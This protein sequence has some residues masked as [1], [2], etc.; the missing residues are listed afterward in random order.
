MGPLMYTSRDGLGR[1]RVKPC[2]DLR[3]VLSALRDG[4]SK[5]GQKT[6]PKKMG[7]ATIRCISL[8]FVLEQ[9]GTS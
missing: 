2:P 8:I 4:S 7:A 6:E 1:P 5:D 3:H 9:R